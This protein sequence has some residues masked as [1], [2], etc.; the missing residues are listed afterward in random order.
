ME[1]THVLNEHLLEAAEILCTKLVP[2]TAVTG[3]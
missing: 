3:A 1:L 2:F